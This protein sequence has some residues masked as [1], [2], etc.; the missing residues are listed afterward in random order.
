MSERSA[1]PSLIVS[2]I[3]RRFGTGSA[4]GNARHTGHVCVLGSPP[5]PLRQRQNI[6]VSV[7]SWTWISSPITGSHSATELLLR[8]ANGVLDRAAHRDVAEAVLERTPALDQPELALA[9]L[10]LQLE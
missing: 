6:F 3:A 10:E 7:F 5:K 1:R 9:R 4:P 2:S 8:L